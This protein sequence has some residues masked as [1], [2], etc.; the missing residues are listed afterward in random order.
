MDTLFIVL[1][2]VFIFLA[3]ATKPYFD[4]ILSRKDSIHNPKDIDA[5][6]SGLVLVAVFVIC[7]YSCK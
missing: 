1:A 5:L 4:I 7:F 3:A 2:S 6:R